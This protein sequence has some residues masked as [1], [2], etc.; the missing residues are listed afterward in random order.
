MVFSGD[1]DADRIGI[2]APAQR[3]P[4][5]IL[6]PPTTTGF[7]STRVWEQPPPSSPRKRSYL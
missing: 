5:R 2:G 6:R 3:S 7:E 1:V 4:K